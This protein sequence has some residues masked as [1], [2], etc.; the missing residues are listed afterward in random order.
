MNDIEEVGTKEKWQWLEGGCITK[1]MEG[2]IMAT[3]SK[4]Y[5]SGALDPGFKR[6]R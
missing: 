3:Q 2:F 1:S 6:K 4:L 5:E